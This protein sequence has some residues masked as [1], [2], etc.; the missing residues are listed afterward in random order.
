M[1]FTFFNPWRMTTIKN[2]F[3]N[4]FFFKNNLDT[5]TE[6]PENFFPI[7]KTG[8]FIHGGIWEVLLIGPCFPEW[9]FV[10]GW[11]VFGS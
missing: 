2:I 11:C 3:N 5:W 6:N 10:Y 8:F 4:I 9:F 7:V 1:L